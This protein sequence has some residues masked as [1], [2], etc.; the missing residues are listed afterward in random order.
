MRRTTNECLT[1]KTRPMWNPLRF[2]PKPRRRTFRQAFSAIYID[3]S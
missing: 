1:G 3:E 2:E